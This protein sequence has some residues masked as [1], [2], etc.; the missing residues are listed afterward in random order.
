[1]DGPW[2]LGVTTQSSIPPCD[3]SLITGTFTGIPT[4][5]PS[6]EPGKGQLSVVSREKEAP[7]TFL[8]VCVTFPEDLGS[9]LLCCPLSSPCLC[10]EVQWDQ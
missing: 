5:V 6:C 4:C 2:G 1:M 10:A 9:C 3:P 7:S 8:P